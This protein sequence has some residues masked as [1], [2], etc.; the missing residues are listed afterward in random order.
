MRRLPTSR[1]QYFLEDP[2]IAFRYYSR[3]TRKVAA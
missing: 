2:R 1:R 3:L